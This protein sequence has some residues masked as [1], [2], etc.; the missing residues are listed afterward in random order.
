MGFQIV[1][2]II[3]ILLVAILLYETY[4]LLKKSGAASVFVGVFA[5]ILVWFLVSR[6]FEMQL[7]GGLF[8]KV[9]NVGAI[10]L[11]V[12]FQDEIRMFF[13]RIGDNWR[14]FDMFKQL[15]KK[16][17]AKSKQQEADQSVVQIVLACKNM[18]RTKTGALIV[19]TR[20]QDLQQYAVSGERIDAMIN[21]R[22]IENIFFKNSPLHD[23][24][25]LI[26]GGRLHSAACILPISKK[27]NIPK[28]F[29]LRHR[30]ALGIAEK[31]DAIAVV[32]SEETGK[33]SYVIGDEV[34]TGVKPEELEQMLSEQWYD[35]CH[36]N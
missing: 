25:L 28:Q 4:K 18:S 11:I 32:V 29:G 21:S 23:G 7:L 3:D 13:S 2:D 14:M 9:I 16:V 1:K 15:S 36:A 10:A 5:F 26:V 30:A 6:V 34:K 22:L 35:Y 19:F 8:D 17:R 31:T 27:Q 24:A 12:I 33:I 20:K